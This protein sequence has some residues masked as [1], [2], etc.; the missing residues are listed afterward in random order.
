MPVTSRI[1]CT[2]ITVLM[3]ACSGQPSKKLVR[4]NAGALTNAPLPII[5]DTCLLRD[6]AMGQDHFVITEAQQAASGLGREA[7]AY[8]SKNKLATAAPIAPFVCGTLP[9]ES[10][11]KPDQTFVS[12]SRD[13]SVGPATPPFAVAPELAAGQLNSDFATLLHHVASIHTAESK[14]P[15]PPPV[16]ASLNPALADLRRYLGADTVLVLS[17]AGIEVSKTKAIAQ[18]VATATATVLLFGFGVG[19][20]STSGA[21][22]RAT[23]I[24][25]RSGTAVWSNRAPRQAGNPFEADFYNEKLV[26]GLLYHL[27]HQPGA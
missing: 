4:G 8:L 13:A 7:A 24:D 26:E 23:L 12:A 15:V 1:A 2:A 21:E 25:L 18:G 14:Q 20:M 10:T 3:V 9:F 11:Q 6:N 17:E 16:P 22:L 5:V 27:A 19:S